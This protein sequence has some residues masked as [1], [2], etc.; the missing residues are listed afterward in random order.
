MGCFTAVLSLADGP[1]VGGWA[2]DLQRHRNRGTDAA[3]RV[4]TVAAL[5]AAAAPWRDEVYGEW[6]PP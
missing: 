3:G 4:R 2:T 6:S 1:I 5:V